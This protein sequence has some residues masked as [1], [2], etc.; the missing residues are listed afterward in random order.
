[1]INLAEN[2]KAEFA[3]ISIQQNNLVSTNGGV[4]HINIPVVSPYGIATVPPKG[5]RVVVLPT[6]NT[7][8]CLGTPQKNN[9]LE[10]GELMLFSSGGASIV[11]KNNGKVFINGKEM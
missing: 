6:G 10:E 5:E 7:A 11:L 2:T 4:P 3:E 8:V 9:N 1:V